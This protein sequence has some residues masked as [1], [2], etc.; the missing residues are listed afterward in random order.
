M[1][2]LFPR[3]YEYYAPH[4]AAELEL[5]EQH[6]AKGDDVIIVQCDGKLMSC[7]ENI[8]HRYEGCKRCMYCW[9][10]VNYCLPSAA[11]IIAYPAISS[12]EKDDVNNCLKSITSE[13]DLKKFC[14]KGLDVGYAILSSMISRYRNSSFN[15]KD[16]LNLARRLA[17]SY[18]YLYYA[19]RKIL[20]EYRIDLV[21]IFNGRLAGFRAIMRACEELHI[22]F[23][24]HDRGCCDAKYMIFKNA[25]PHDLSLTRELIEEAWANR[26]ADDVVEKIVHEYYYSRRLTQNNLFLKKQRAGYQPI[27]L[28]RNQIN[29]AIY[30]SSED[31]FAAISD[32][33]RFR[34]F[35]SQV[36]ALVQLAMRFK[37]DNRVQL[38]VRYHPNHNIV[39]DPLIG[40]IEFLKNCGCVVIQP[41]SEVCS[42]R[43][44]EEVD[45][46]VVF[47]STI[48]AEAV[49]WRKPCILLGPALY[50]GLGD[51]FYEPSD[52]RSCYDLVSSRLTPKSTIS[53]Y[54]FG[55]YC[56]TF[57]I[58][59]EK[60]KANSPWSGHYSGFSLDARYVAKNY[61]MILSRV[62]DRCWL[63]YSKILCTGRIKW[64]Y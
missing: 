9:S 46:V 13:T 47:G 62:W 19:T 53:A 6:I 14:Y 60:Y 23:Y 59:Y 54:K 20:N 40:I 41:S 38:V 55:Y 34:L 37:N 15:A 33:W 16:D 5:I 58:N 57:G 28:N 26:P 32:E 1:V 52:I 63:A 29:V 49:Y 3:L 56:S 7:D 17:A 10:H 18:L 31:E 35:S 64:S 30:T 51:S 45:T 44:M 24:T 43:L 42:Y 61:S 25:M 39:F 11:K 2:V 12:E 8:D 27:L 48:G 22:N 4:S 50:A 36:D 21:Y